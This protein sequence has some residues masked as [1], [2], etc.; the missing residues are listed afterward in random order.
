MHDYI[1]MAAIV[2]TVLCAQIHIKRTISAS[3]TY[4]KSPAVMAAIHCLVA[5]SVATDRAIYR[6][7]NEVMA[8]P[9]FKSNALRTDTPLW[10]KMAKS[11]GETQ[12]QQD[13]G[14]NERLS[15]HALLAF[16]YKCVC[17]LYPVHVVVRGRAQLVM[18][19]DL[20]SMTGRTQR[21]SLSRLQSCGSRHR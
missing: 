9:T 21:P 13:D 19:P 15:N 5:R 6:P 10:S 14:N 4:K 11:P 8:L 18:W 12:K 3:P 7:T 1:L 16:L 20:T 17:V 2:W